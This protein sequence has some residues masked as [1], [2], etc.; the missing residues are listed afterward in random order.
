MY[1]EEIWN[2]FGKQYNTAVKIIELD[3]LISAWINYNITSN[4]K[5]FLKDAY[6]KT[7]RVLLKAHPQKGLYIVSVYILHS[8]SN[9]NK[10]ER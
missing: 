5:K 10:Q 1:T 7:T 2:K 3:L 8:K 4:I 6:R 9:F